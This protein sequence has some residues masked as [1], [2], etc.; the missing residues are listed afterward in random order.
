MATSE[1]LLAQDSAQLSEQAGDTLYTEGVIVTG[2]GTTWRIR[3]RFMDRFKATLK[4][5]QRM[6][7]TPTFVYGA[8]VT[9]DFLPEKAD[10]TDIQV[11]DV[12]SAVLYAQAPDDTVDT[13]T[14]SA[15]NN[16]WQYTTGTGDLDQN[17]YWTGTFVV[18]ETAGAVYKYNVAFNVEGQVAP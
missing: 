2:G 7:I 17:G 10:G 5:R 6:S 12:S 16:R 11:A 3:A 18:T 1:I 8:T 15:T 13:W 14:A 4:P 9:F